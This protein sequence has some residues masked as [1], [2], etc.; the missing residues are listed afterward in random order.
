MGGIMADMSDQEQV[1][2]LLLA[3]DYCEKEAAGSDPVLDGYLSQ[4]SD[5]SQALFIES[6]QTFRIL[7]REGAYRP[8]N[9]NLIV[10]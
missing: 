10:F 9:L 7:R 5:D 2:V 6:V 1:Q 4:L 8:R 3:A